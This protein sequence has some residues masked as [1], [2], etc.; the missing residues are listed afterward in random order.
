MADIYLTF[1]CISEKKLVIL[2]KTRII[3]YY[4]KSKVVVY[5]FAALCI[6]AAVGNN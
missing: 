1:S 5:G 6:L 3:S 2:Q 4:M